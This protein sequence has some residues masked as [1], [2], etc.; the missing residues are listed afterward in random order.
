M[1]GVAREEDA[2]VAVAIGDEQVRG[3]APDVEDLGVDRRRRPPAPRADVDRCRREGCRAV[4]SDGGRPGRSDR[5]TRHP[6]CCSDARRRAGGGRAGR[7]NGRTRETSATPRRGR[8]VRSRAACA[9]CSTRR[10]SP[11]DSRREPAWFRSASTM[12]AVTPLASCAKAV[13]PAPEPD[14]DVGRRFGHRAQER[15]ER[16]L[17]D[18]LVRLAGLRAV[19]TL[20]DERLMLAG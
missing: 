15:L 11:P 13:E 6:R 16:V 8:R 18:A 12:W 3:P 5:P 20:G 14:D 17:R 1:G 9:R 19:V 4:R 10:H 2:T 7:R